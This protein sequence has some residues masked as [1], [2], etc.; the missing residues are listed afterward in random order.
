MSQVLGHLQTYSPKS[1]KFDP[2]RL[3]SLPLSFSDKTHFLTGFEGWLLLQIHNRRLKKSI[4]HAQCARTVAEG[5]GWSTWPFLRIE[6]NFV[7]LILRNIINCWFIVLHSTYELVNHKWSIYQ[8]GNKS[9]KSIFC[10]Y[11]YNVSQFIH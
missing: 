2:K 3:L 10:K 9:L 7:R 6:I 11:E 5:R 4:H 1:P 8:I